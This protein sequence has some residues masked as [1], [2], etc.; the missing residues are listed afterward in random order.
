MQSFEKIGVKELENAIKAIGDDWMLITVEDKGNGRVNAMTASWGALGVLWNKPVCICFVRSE[1]HTYKLLGEKK[2]LSIAFLDKDRRDAL[3]I[4]GRES[5]ADIDKLSKCGL[6][7]LE[8][9]G[10]PVIAEAQTAL[11]CRVLYED[12]LKEECFLDSSLLSNYASA[13]YHRVFICEIM[14]AYKK[15]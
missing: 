5:G 15:V 4:C 11:T 8:R 1:R 7:T 10:V 2:E 3:L 9:D 12:D 6:S 13:G 14:G